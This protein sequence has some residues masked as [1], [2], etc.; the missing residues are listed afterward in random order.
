MRRLISVM[1]V[2]AT[3]AASAFALAGGTSILAK[4]GELRNGADNTHQELVGKE[5]ELRNGID[6]QPQIEFIG[7]GNDN[8]PETETN[9]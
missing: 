3:L 7:R 8:A 9:G 5:G 6:G 2:S 4:E 1:A